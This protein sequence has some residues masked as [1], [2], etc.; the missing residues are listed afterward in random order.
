MYCLRYGTSM[1]EP[2]RFVAIYYTTGNRRQSPDEYTTPFTSLACEEQGSTNSPDIWSMRDS[3]P[4]TVDIAVRVDL[5]T[6]SIHVEQTP[7]AHA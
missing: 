1:G 3:I 2:C 5:Q 7:A 6:N 4:R